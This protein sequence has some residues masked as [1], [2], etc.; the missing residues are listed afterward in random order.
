MLL[1]AATVF[2]SKGKPTGG[3]NDPPPPPLAPP[4][5]HTHSSGFGKNRIIL[6]ADMSSSVQM[7]NKKNHIL[8][9]SKGPILTVEKEYPIRFSE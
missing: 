6:D 1:N 9:F 8:V 4:H 5:T 2:D 7:D 3:W